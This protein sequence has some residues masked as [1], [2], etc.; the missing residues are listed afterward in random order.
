MEFYRWIL[1]AGPGSDGAAFGE[2]EDGA[3]E[4]VFEGEE[5]RGC[6]M[7]VRVEDGVGADVGEGY[8]MAVC[9]GYGDGLCAAEG[10]DA[11]GFP[12]GVG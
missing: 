12:G 9:W 6:E 1:R 8:V 3:A 10:G 2:G 11:A 5:A 7:V 4:G